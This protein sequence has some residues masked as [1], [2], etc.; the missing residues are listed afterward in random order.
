L[1]KFFTP[2]FSSRFR[3]K[4]EL[5]E[6]C[7]EIGQIAKLLNYIGNCPIIENCTKIDQKIGKLTKTKKLPKVRNLPKI[8]DLAK[9]RKIWQNVGKCPKSIIG[10]K[11]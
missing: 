7:P 10:Q 8:A 5:Y 2:N 1:L 6:N 11:S 3:G 9:I 4:P